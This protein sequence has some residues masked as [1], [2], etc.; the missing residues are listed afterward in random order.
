M[1]RDVGFAFPFNFSDGRTA[2]V[3][4]QGL[5]SPTNDDR[6]AAVRAGVTQI[7][8]TEKMG[9][10]MFG[11]LGAGLGRY[12][13]DPIPGFSSLIPM[14][15]RRAVG[16]WCPRAVVSDV[17]QQLFPADG[18]IVVALVVRHDDADAESVIRVATRSE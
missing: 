17:K 4:G 5:A 12:L 18:R 14:E 10:V 7:L 1:N 2:T 9:R 11:D 8:L 15:V 16:D 6:D 3:G 13:F